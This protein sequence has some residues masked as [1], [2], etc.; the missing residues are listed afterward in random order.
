MV[1]AEKGVGRLQAACLGMGK[2]KARLAAQQSA[3]LRRCLGYA[4]AGLLLGMLKVAAGKGAFACCGTH[5]MCMLRED[6]S[7][8]RPHNTHNMSA[9]IPDPGSTRQEGI[10]CVCVPERICKSQSQ[11]EMVILP[12]PV[13]LF[14]FSFFFQKSARKRQWQVWVWGG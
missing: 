6:Y 11:K 13:H 7:L 14:F 10:K 5:V 2:H 8:Q 3:K 12:V 4:V 9:K 1:G